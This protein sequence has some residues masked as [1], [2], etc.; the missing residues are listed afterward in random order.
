M[1][2]NSSKD[3]LII[4]QGVVVTGSIKAAGTVQVDGTI[5][6]T[7]E[8]DELLVGPI[9]QINGT[10]TTRLA[11]V[12]GQVTQSLYVSERL[13]VMSTGRVEGRLSYKSIA[14]EHGGV[15]EGAVVF[16]SDEKGIGYPV[17]GSSV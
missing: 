5:D 12:R 2:V 10:V 3:C 9:G 7:L 13:T 4:G 17:G 11:E 16:L 1:D 14:V 8:A 6:G 15:V